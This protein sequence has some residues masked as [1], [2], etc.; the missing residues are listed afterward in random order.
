LKNFLLY[1]EKNN[2]I[3]DLPE[4]DEIAINTNRKLIVT[5]DN[6]ESNNITEQSNDFGIFIFDATAKWSNAKTEYSL[7]NINF[8]ARANQL[9]T[10]IGPVG[11]GKVCIKLTGN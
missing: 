4:T 11:A 2:Q 3:S 8:T 10:I 1:E 6:F 9:I 7:K 5:H